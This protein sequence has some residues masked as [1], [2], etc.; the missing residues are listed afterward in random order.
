MDLDA[1]NARVVELERRVTKL[2]NHSEQ[3]ASQVRVSESKN[4]L[5]LD[6]AQ[7][8]KQ[9]LTMGVSCDDGIE[10]SLINASKDV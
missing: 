4:F 10:Q 3:S 6:E 9:R 2:E 7:T 8:L 5:L 1:R